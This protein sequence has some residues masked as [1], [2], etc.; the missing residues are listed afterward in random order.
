MASTQPTLGTDWTGLGTFVTVLCGGIVLIINAWW[1]G[2][3]S[4]LQHAETVQKLNENTQVTQ[5]AAIKAAEAKVLSDD[6]NKI[7]RMQGTMDG[8]PMPPAPD[9]AKAVLEVISG[10]GDGRIK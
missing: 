1:Q 8:G 3:K 5:A 4:T 7:I 9:T 6:T 2:K 10:T